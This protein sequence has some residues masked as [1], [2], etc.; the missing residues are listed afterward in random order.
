MPRGQA[1][2]LVPAV[3]QVLEKAGGVFSDVDLIATTVGPGAFTGLRIG[4]STAQ[5]FGLALKKPV[6][7]V[8]TLE[9]LAAQ[10]FADNELSEQLLCV[11]I[12]TKRQDYY[13]QFFNADG[14]EYTEPQALA[15]E[16]VRDI[17]GEKEALYIGDAI[18]RFSEERFADDSTKVCKGYELPDPCLIASM[19]LERYE[20]NNIRPPEPLYLRGADVSS[21][22]KEQ[23]VILEE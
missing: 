23:R 5:A 1:E 13:C 14:T 9:I 18:K 20:K 16:A 3:Q 21:S 2:A 12:E 15:G 22:K 7:G 19:A 6:A 4:L 11:L 10:Y 17:Q 8:T